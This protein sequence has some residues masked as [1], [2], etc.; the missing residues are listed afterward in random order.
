MINYS[1]EIPG[2]PV[3]KGRP[4]MTK[5]GHAYTPQHTRDYDAWV[6]LCWLQTGQ[7]MSLQPLQ[8]LLKF[9]L[10]IPKSF[11]KK[12]RE[13][14]LAGVLLPTKKPDIDNL[15]KAVLD[16]LNG[17]AYQDD[18]QIVYLETCKAYGAVPLV[19]VTLQE[20]GQDDR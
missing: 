6:R 20:V 8:I 2:V 15:V 11:R 3:P 7:P 14:A 13:L 10:P 16:G 17:L 18:K 1:F 5:S 9:Y 19:Q 12:Q 4:R